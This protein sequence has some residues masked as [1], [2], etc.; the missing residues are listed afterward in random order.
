MIK[1]SYRITWSSD[2]TETA[3]RCVSKSLSMLHTYI[4]SHQPSHPTHRW[5]IHLVLSTASCTLHLSPFRCLCIHLLQQPV[6]SDWRHQ[7][8]RQGF[9]YTIN[10]IAELNWAYQADHQIIPWTALA[11]TQDSSPPPALVTSPPPAP[12]LVS[13]R[14]YI[15][16]LK[17]GS[18][19]TNQQPASI[20]W[21]LT[22]LT[23]TLRHPFIC[24]SHLSG[25]GMSLRTENTELR[26]WRTK[27]DW[28]TSVSQ[29]Q[30]YAPLWSVRSCGHTQN[31]IGPLAMDGGGGHQTSTSH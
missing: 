19:S 2:Q 16:A 1:I 27:A 11:W 25:L 28:T 10:C 5:P 3:S 22:F 9:D 15:T 12:E 14:C 24:A 17:P 26:T 31:H 21:H 8:C 6:S 30:N 18:P 29:T 20:T 13:F 23:P 7:V 4:F